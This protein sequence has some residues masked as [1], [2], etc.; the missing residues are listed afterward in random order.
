MGSERGA[1][2]VTQPRP[3]SGKSSHIVVNPIVKATTRRARVKQ[4]GRER[5]G[6]VRLRPIHRLAPLLLLPILP[7]S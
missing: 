3:A 5:Q 2:Q 4:R 6:N 7:A 1:R